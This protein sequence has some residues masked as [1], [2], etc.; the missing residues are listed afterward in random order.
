MPSPIASSVAEQT[1]FE[2]QTAVVRLQIQ[3][4]V[5]AWLGEHGF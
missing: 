1:S 2:V 4:L 3:S 5:L